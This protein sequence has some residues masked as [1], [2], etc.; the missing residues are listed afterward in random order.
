MRAPVLCVRCGFVRTARADRVSP[1]FSSERSSTGRLA[2]HWC[3]SLPSHLCCALRL[4]SKAGYSWFGAAVFLR[5]TDPNDPNK[6][7]VWYVDMPIANDRVQDSF[8]VASCVQLLLQEVKA[9]A[10]SVTSC[11]IQW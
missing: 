7:E 2:H 3:M 11:E 5:G 4:L 1:C 6:V 9:L 10:P 8:Q